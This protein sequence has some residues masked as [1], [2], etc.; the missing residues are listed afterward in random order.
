MIK[1]LVLSATVASVATTLAVVFAAPAMAAGEAKNV[2]FFLGDGMGP[3]TKTAAR[4]YKYNEAGS[5][6]M[7]TMPYT[8]RIKTYSLDA[9]TTDSAPSM[10]AYMTGVKERNDVVS[11]SGDTIAKAPSKDA[12]T[13]VANAVTNCA[14]TGNGTAV[15]TLTEYAIAQGKATGTVTTARLTHATPA[16]TY[17]HSCHR[18]AE[19]EIAR[20][21]IP[22]GSGFSG[23][24]SGQ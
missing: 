2:I 14:P 3:V 8:A 19:Y 9:Q 21:A 24:F 15:M 6:G 23:S 16:A 13:N 20:Q 7:D 10:A 4:I 11:M 18:D 12:T 5:L 22:G 17:A 1:K